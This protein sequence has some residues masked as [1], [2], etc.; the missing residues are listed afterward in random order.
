V[1]IFLFADRLVTAIFGPGFEQAV[2]PLRILV[3]AGVAQGTARMAISAVRALGSPLRSSAAH[4]V[5]IVTTAPLALWLVRYGIAGVAVA[6]LAGQLVVAVIAYIII[7][8]QGAPGVVRADA[9]V[10]TTANSG[11][12]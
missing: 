10:P 3:F 4:A 5:G 1:P 7:E 11:P 8:R 2:A 9:T 6:T 12:P